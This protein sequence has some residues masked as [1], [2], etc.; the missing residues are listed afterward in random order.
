MQM[1]G[2]EMNSALALL[3]TV[4]WR[5]R[6]FKVALFVFLLSKSALFLFWDFFWRLM[7]SL[8]ISAIVSFLVNEL[9]RL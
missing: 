1:T 5:E 4:L 2:S 3:E 6:P 8:L 9:G 7:F